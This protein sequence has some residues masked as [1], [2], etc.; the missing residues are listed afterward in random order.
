MENHINSK[1]EEVVMNLD[2]ELIS[3]FGNAVFHCPETVSIIMK[4]DFKDGSSVC[5]QRE[6]EE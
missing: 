6:K 1:Q 4:I 5:Y 3:K 2:R